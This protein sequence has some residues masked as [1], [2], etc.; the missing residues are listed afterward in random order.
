[1]KVN[2]NQKVTLTIGQL[3]KL[4][5]EARTSQSVST[6]AIPKPYDHFYQ[7]EK[8]DPE[9]HGDAVVPGKPIPGHAKYGKVV[10]WLVANDK[11][12]DDLSDNGDERVVLTNK[13][14]VYVVPDDGDWVGEPELPIDEDGHYDGELDGQGGY[15]EYDS[16]MDMIVHIEA[17][18][19]RTAKRIKNGTMDFDDCLYKHRIHDDYYIDGDL[20]VLD[21]DGSTS[22]SSIAA[23]VQAVNDGNIGPSDDEDEDED[24]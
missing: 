5:K 17:K 20:V 13:N 3:K 23:F 4:V 6:I 18:A 10:A 1:M 21:G 11:Y 12:F 7:V 24:Y 9:V 19:A 15:Y 8:Y 22:S 16:E 14:K 2:E